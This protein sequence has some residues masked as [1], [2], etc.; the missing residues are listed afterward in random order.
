MRAMTDTQPAP[1]QP[2]WATFT[3]D[4]GI[5]LRFLY[6]EEQYLAAK[7]GH[8]AD[9]NLSANYRIVRLVEADDLAAV[10]AERDDAVRKREVTPAFARST[11]HVTPMCCWRSPM[12]SESECPRAG[13]WLRWAWLSVVLAQLSSAWISWYFHNIEGVGTKL[14]TAFAAGT[15]AFLL[16]PGD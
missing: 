14:I 7:Q 11:S 4:D 2:L 8:E 15:V 10:T 9:E 3:R 13:R 12:Q 16:R 1:M 6:S 5:P